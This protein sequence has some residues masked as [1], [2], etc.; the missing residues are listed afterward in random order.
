MEYFS[1][2]DQILPL[3]TTAKKSYLSIS[4]QGVSVGDIGQSEDSWVL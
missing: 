2:L 4:V 1:A 3:A